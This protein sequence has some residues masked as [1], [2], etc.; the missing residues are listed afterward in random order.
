MLGTMPIITPIIIPSSGGGEDLNA[1]ELVVGTLF[2]L[3]IFQATLACLC[4]FDPIVHSHKQTKKMFFFRMFP[5][6]WPVSI[7]VRKFRELD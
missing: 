3:Y 6:V 2:C 5:F 1:T 7:L 4:T